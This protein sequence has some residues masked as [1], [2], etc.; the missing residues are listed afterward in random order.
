[1]TDK[2]GTVD[3][4][5][6]A[7]FGK[8]GAGV[9]T[10]GEMLLAAAA[11]AGLY[12]MM[13]RAV[14][15]QIRGGE[16]AALIRLGQAPINCLD[17][18][19]DLL[20][21][22]GW[23]HAERL[24]GDIALDAN[25]IVV[26]D[27]GQDQVPEA[28][29]AGGSKVRELPMAELAESIEGGRA[30]MVALGYLAA[31]AGI[32]RNAVEQAIE[33]KLGHKGRQ[34]VAASNDAAKLGYTEAGD[35]KTAAPK[36]TNGVADNRWMMSGN[37]ATGLGAMRGGIRFAAA[38]P[39]TP[40][41]EILE[42]LAPRLNDAG[43]TLAQAE[44]EL[45][46]INMAIGA[47]YGGIPSLTATS[48]PGLSLMIESIGLA[49]C[50]EIPLVIV[51]VMR[52]GPSTGIPT[53]SEQSDFNSAVYGVHGDAPHIVVAPNS[54]TDCIYTTQWAVHL[55]E[56]TQ[57]PVIVLSDQFIGQASVIAEPV[58]E[59]TFFAKRKLA[60]D[61]TDEFERY[62]ITADGV[63][64]M[65]LP[66]MPGGQYTADGLEHSPKAVP[67]GMTGNHNE[68]LD[69]RARKIAQFDYGQHWA[70]IEGDGDLAILT[71]GSTTSVTREAIGRLPKELRDRV[72]LIS[73]RLLLPVRPDDM[74]AALDG[75]ARV[76]VIE[77]NHSGQFYRFL[78][79]WYELPADVRSMHRPGPAVFRPGEIAAAIQEWSNE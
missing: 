33:K 24:L 17:D 3:S 67:S 58:P 44:D 32:P 59:I 35:A 47:S 21:A 27:P 42:W 64:P 6:I 22:I 45:A 77:L 12:G 8:G 16:A 79:A 74:T 23:K 38:Y 43:G 57:A 4:F 40:A 39:I 52:G 53:S 54:V 30:N 41:T 7:L 19:I 76:M 50:A 75:I 14:G 70:D 25:S 15:P 46:S 71:W 10:A 69:K 65:P 28:I 37:H 61:I 60:E 56:A 49:V 5:S 31:V 68:Q 62:A 55:A 1:M 20:L 13:I 78:R 26:T 51:N 2:P 48:G 29:I 72:K 66:G 63:S 11:R 34:S 9:I 73:P 36:P 18:R